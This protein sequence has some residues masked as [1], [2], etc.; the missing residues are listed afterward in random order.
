MGKGFLQRRSV[1]FGVPFLLLVVGGSFG[2][3][4]FAQIRYDFR[5]RKNVS[6]AD[7]EKMGIRMKEQDEV[8]L[9]TEFKKIERIDTTNWE[10]VRGP[11]PW[12]EGNQL[13][14]E[15]EERAKKIAKQD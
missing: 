3:K 10:N 9:E 7:A 8:T 14:K 5:N 15:A 11:R 4:E 12:E 1:R 2:L 6:K 13:Y